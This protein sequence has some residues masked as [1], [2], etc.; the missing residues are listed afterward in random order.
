MVLK[1]YAM[2][3]IQSSDIWDSLYHSIGLY[4]IFESAVENI[5]FIFIL[6][7][8]TARAKNSYPI[9]YE[10]AAIPGE[11]LRVNLYSDLVK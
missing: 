6:Q 5:L 4:F 1:F 10:L 8:K 7:D 9:C 11:W 2:S 3:F